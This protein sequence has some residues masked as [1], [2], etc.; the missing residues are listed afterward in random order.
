MPIPMTR[1]HITVR[2]AG[3][4]RTQVEYLVRVTGH[5]KSQVLRDAIAVLHA[6]RCKQGTPR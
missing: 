5:T 1:S 3:E 4:S 2:V 6:Q